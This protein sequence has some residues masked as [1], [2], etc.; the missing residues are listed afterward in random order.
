[1]NQ[2]H[3]IYFMSKPYHPALLVFVSS[4]LQTRKH[5]LSETKEDPSFP[6]LCRF[7]V[8][9]MKQT[10]SSRRWFNL[11]SMC[12][13]A[14]HFVLC[15]LRDHFLS[16]LDTRDWSFHFKE[17]ARKNGVYREKSCQESQGAVHRVT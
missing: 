12:L 6:N 5:R 14:D 9:F 16:I 2:A 7:M 15:Y 17:D 13:T 4:F 8:G 1:M 10:M 11:Y 3:F